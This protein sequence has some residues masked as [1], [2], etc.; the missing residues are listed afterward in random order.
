MPVYVPA[1]A[2]CDRCGKT[3]PCWLSCMFD[4]SIGVGN[5]GAAIRGLGMWF[6]KDNGMVCSEACKEAIQSDPRWA[7]YGKWTAC[8]E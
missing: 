3:A 1:Q 2:I 7:R 6:W 5:F 8:S 4:D